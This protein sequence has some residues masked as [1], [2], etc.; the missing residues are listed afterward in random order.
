MTWNDLNCE[1]DELEHVIHSHLDTPLTIDGLC[2][3]TKGD[4]ACAIIKLRSD[5]LEEQKQ[6]QE[7]WKEQERTI[8]WLRGCHHYGKVW[9]NGFGEESVRLSDVHDFLASSPPH[10]WKTP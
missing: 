5:W 2:R 8:A 4:L 9:I 6:D 7:E 1:L 10:E 3:M